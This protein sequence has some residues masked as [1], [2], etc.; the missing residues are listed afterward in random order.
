MGEYSIISA[1]YELSHYAPLV[2]LVAT[3]LD[4]L[5]FTGYIFYG[6]AM[7][8]SILVLHTAGMISTEA[9]FISA[10]F[11]TLLGNTGNYLI[12]WFLGNTTYVQK[13][14]SHQRV[15]TVKRYLSNHGLFV[16]MVTGRCITFTRP[17]YALLLGS[18]NISPRR[19]FLYETIIAFVW[20]SFWLLVIIEGEAL[21]V[22]FFA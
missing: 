12:G 6:F 2:V 13:K 4:I 16:F 10:Y 17:M 3:I 22:R 7:L 15:V 11:G 5:I 21:Y 19:F 8:S 20:V 14:L 9:L 18:M 1:V